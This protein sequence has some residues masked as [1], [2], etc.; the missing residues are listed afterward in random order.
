MSV[1]M[2]VQ[3]PA[4]AP[5]EEAIEISSGGALVANW[6]H[7]QQSLFGSWLPGRSVG[8]SSYET[9]YL[10]MTWWQSHESPGSLTQAMPDSA[11]DTSRTL[12][13][14][15]T[16]THAHFHCCVCLRGLRAQ[17]RKQRQG[18]GTPTAADYRQTFSSV[19]WLDWRHL[20][21]IYWNRFV[22]MHSLL[23][24]AQSDE[25]YNIL[26]AETNTHASEA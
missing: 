5:S 4:S 26:H 19:Q 24:I 8:D 25:N 7:R 2:S 21:Q 16:H 18:T 3:L 9:L 17:K 10:C 6:W 14:I 15:R 23:W 1:R 20:A 13:A 22:T 11:S 12:T